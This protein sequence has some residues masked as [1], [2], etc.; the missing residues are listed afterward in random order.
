MSTEAGHSTCLR[1]AVLGCDS[2][3]SF[4]LGQPAHR[5]KKLLLLGDMIVA[6]PGSYDAYQEVLLQLRH[7]L[8][9]FP[10]AE[11]R[12]D[13]Q[14]WLKE[15]HAQFEHNDYDLQLVFGWWS[16]REGRAVLLHYPFLTHST[17]T[18]VDAPSGCLCHQ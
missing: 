14:R 2:Q 15:Q 3:S 10:P 5:T 9:D 17:S 16:P 18:W 6:W 12:R 11:R 1:G 4:G 8:G 7:E 13:R